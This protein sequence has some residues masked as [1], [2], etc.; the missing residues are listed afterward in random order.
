AIFIRVSIARLVNEVRRVAWLAR[1]RAR[2]PRLARVVRPVFEL[3]FRRS[4][5]CLGH[6]QFVRLDVLQGLGGFPTSGATED[7][8][9]GYALGARGVLMAAMP[10]L[11][12]VDMPETNAGMIRQNARWYKGVL[13]D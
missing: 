8:T 10:L 5:I 11:E 6:N 4:Q 2:A 1:L 13:D 9:L 12:L 7:S 3:C